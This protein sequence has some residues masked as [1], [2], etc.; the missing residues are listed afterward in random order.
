M[1]LLTFVG[2]LQGWDSSG[3]GCAWRAIGYAGL[4]D[5]PNRFIVMPL[6]I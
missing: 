2:V 6:T 3:G 1:T 4:Q 5:A